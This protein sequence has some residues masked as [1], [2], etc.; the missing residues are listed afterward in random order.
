MP[1]IGVI[2]SVRENNPY[3]QAC[4][5]SLKNEDVNL[6]VIPAADCSGNARIEGYEKSTSPYICYIDDDDVV[7][8]GAFARAKEIITSTGAKTYYT[9]HYVADENLNPYGV[10]F[11]N[12]A[13]KGLSQHMQMHHIVVYSRDVIGPY[14]KYL[15]NVTTF[16]KKILNYASILHG[17]VVGTTKKEL[18]WRIHKNNNH[19]EKSFRDNP[20]EW[21][22]VVNGLELQIKEKYN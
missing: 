17:S 20:K 15:K 21:H 12:L 4:L 3:L 8:P 11:T 10:R 1:E 5:D 14:I 19:K 18:Y 13:P 22:D 7:V 2:V 9:N 16:D 6:L